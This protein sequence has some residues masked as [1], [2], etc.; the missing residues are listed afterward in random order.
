MKQALPPHAK[1]AKDAKESIQTCVSEFIAFITS[2]ASDKCLLEKRKTINGEDLLHAMTTLGFAPYILPLQTYLDKYKAIV[3]GD[4]PEKIEKP[5]YI[6]KEKP[7]KM[8]KM[9]HASSS[10]S[11]SSSV[12]TEN[13]VMQHL[14]QGTYYI[15]ATS[16]HAVFQDQVNHPPQPKLP[17]LPFLPGAQFT[18]PFQEDG[19]NCASNTSKI[20]GIE[21]GVPGYRIDYTQNIPL[22]DP[23]LCILGKY[24]SY[25]E[26][27][28]V[29]STPPDSHFNAV[30][31]DNDIST[32]HNLTSTHS[33]SLP[34]S[35]I[36][37]KI[38][39]FLGGGNNNNDDTIDASQLVITSIEVDEY[40]M[41]S[42][43]SAVN[44][45]ENEMGQVDGI[46]ANI[47]RSLKRQRVQIN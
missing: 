23:T 5:K 7:P 2:E 25:L 41:S 47:S 19:Y 26:V 10:S 38:E 39:Q 6:K 36:K 29:M 4:K 17:P 46:A 37:N 45:N 34:P 15:D 44:N 20:D 30:A 42:Y 40:G 18:V 32:K 22:N 1:V 33:S 14:P 21:Y 28:G 43:E 27:P 11:S 3:K 16:H 8:P 12:H 24:T 13:I 31:S 9:K 35:G